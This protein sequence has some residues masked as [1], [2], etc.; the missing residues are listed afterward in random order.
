MTLDHAASDY[1]A[2]IN[3]D[4]HLRELHQAG[5]L[6]PWLWFWLVTYLLMLPSVLVY[7]WQET[8]QPMLSPQPLP[9]GIGGPH[10][11]IMLVLPGFTELLPIAMLLIGVVY[12]FMP[13]LRRRRVEHRY[14]LA[15]P[16]TVTPAIDEI[17]ET[18]REYAPGV[19]VKV[20][21]K[22]ADQV[23]FT[24]ATGYRRSTIAIFGG[25]VKLWRSD[26]EA[27]RAVLLHELGHCRHGDVLMVGAGSFFETLLNA[28]M[29][30]LVLFFI[31]PS[32]I[33]FGGMSISSFQ[34]HWQMAQQWNEV[35]QQ[36]E[37]INAQLRELGLDPVDIGSQGNWF[38][39]W[40]SVF[41]KNLF[42]VELPGSISS[43]IS[44]LVLT[45]VVIAT[46]LMA[47]WCAEFNADQFVV[48]EQR[49]PEPLLRGLA[50]VSPTISRWTW[51]TSRLSHPPTKLR[52][53]MARRG[54]TPQPLL[55]LLLLFPLTYVAKLIFLNI[56]AIA[57]MMIV[58]SPGEML[59]TLLQ[60]N[61]IGLRALA[62]FLLG[63][64]VVLLLYPKLS[65]MWERLFCKERRTTNPASYKEYAIA[66]A[67]VGGLG[68]LA[69]TLAE[70]L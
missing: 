16:S 69:Y 37:N 53:W 4:S 21:L 61:A 2:P 35:S 29:P 47:A 36:S 65:V 12:V 23:A 58:F 45:P 39:G 33:V 60:A 7:H 67:I 13:H 22:R 41:A 62:P 50:L 3:K 11:A 6:P 25:L 17:I 70:M 18:V 31:V 1:T 27:G 42:T 56:R 30:F 44:L 5:V 10:T 55:A 54:R 46:P 8:I 68:V 43:I 9:A 52:Q 28:W 15:L 26:R 63:T 64:G 59:Q 40:L 66:A 57:T 19:E 24:Y 49:S 14:N 32:I 20:N 48:A 38:L 51:L 34:E